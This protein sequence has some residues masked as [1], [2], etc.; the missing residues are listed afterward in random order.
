MAGTVGRPRGLRPEQEAEAARLRTEG[1]SVAD[2]VA[3]YGVS[4]SAMRRT[5]TE[6]GTEG[7]GHPRLLSPAQ[8]AELRDFRGQGWTFSVLAARFGVSARVARLTMERQ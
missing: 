6:R 7:R 5:L 1:A 3:R 8:E 2:L 4:E